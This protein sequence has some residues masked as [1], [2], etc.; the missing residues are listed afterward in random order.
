VDRY[1]AGVNDKSNNKR[2]PDD[3]TQ[4]GDGIGVWDGGE[5]GA[6]CSDGDGGGDC[7]G[8]DGGATRGRRTWMS[9]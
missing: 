9:D 8:G 3:H 7:G 5:G 4:G 1:L 2:H 6:D